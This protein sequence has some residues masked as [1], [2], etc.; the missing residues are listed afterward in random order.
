MDNNLLR[1]FKRIIEIIEIIENRN[2]KFKKYIVEE[3][4]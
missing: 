1:V 4:N 3:R 2:L